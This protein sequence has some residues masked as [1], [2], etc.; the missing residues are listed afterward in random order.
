VTNKLSEKLPFV[1]SAPESYKS[2]T[3]LYHRDP[4][5]STQLYQVT[6]ENQPGF[7]LVGKPIVHLS[8]LKQSSGEAMYVDDM[9][10]FENELYMALV[11]SSKAHAKIISIDP[12]EALGVEGVVDFISAKVSGSKQPSL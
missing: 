1:K 8:G 6:P 9:P 5:K 12:S 3:A 11:L 10:R 4:P 2:A 7:D